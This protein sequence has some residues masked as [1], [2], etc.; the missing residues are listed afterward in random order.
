MALWSCLVIKTDPRWDTKRVTVLRACKTSALLNKALGSFVICIYFSTLDI[1]S[2]Q[3]KW[4]QVLFSISLN[5]LSVIWFL[6][7]TI[8]QKYHFI[9]SKTVPV[10]RG[11]KKRGTPR[12]WNTFGKFIDTIILWLTLNNAYKPVTDCKTSFKINTP[13]ISTMEKL[14]FHTTQSCS[15]WLIERFGESVVHW[16]LESGQSQQCD[17]SVWSHCSPMGTEV[18]RTYM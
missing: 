3:L 6:I 1:N 16:S 9:K 5:M 2:V 13:D 7:I 15:N 17:S 18:N 12:S 10:S 14:R 11:W 8:H 4:V